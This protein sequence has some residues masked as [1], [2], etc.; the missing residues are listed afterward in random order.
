MALRASIA[1]ERE[2]ERVEGVAE[3]VELELENDARGRGVVR[4]PPR[5]RVGA[6]LR[7]SEIKRRAERSGLALVR[8]E[9]HEEE[10]EH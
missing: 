3:R 10:R 6:A 2:G 9:E 8:S 5:Y 7:R 1:G 4:A